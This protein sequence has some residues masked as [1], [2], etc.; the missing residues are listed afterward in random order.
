MQNR[1]PSSLSALRSVLRGLATQKRVLGAMLLREIQIR[2]GRRNLG[3][4]W[5][6]MEP[7]IFALPVLAVWRVVRG[8]YEHGLPIIPFLWTGYLPILAFRHITGH[9]IYAVRNN[10]AVLFHSRVSPLDIVLS[11]C[12][13]EI[14]GNLTATVVSFVLFYGLGFIE[15]PKNP[16][17]FMAGYALMLWWSVCIALLVAAGSE[18]SDLVEHIWQPVSYLYVFYS[19]FMYMAVWVPDAVRPYLLAVNPPLHCY[20]IIRAGMFGGRFQTFGAPSYLMFM[21]AILSVGG[22]WLMRSVRRHLQLEV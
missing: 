14:A 12:G 4:A 8:P 11:K 3:F 5:I 17:L 6:V 10:A 15:F 19:G 16:Y 7:L 2:W 21:L 22:L 13:V 20:E 9:A 1:N 18:M